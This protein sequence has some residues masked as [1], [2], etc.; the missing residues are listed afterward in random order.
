MTRAGRPGREARWRSEGGGLTF[1]GTA[2]Q[3]RLAITLPDRYGM[4]LELGV[5][6]NAMV[7]LSADLESGAAD[8]GRRQ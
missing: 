7:H 4:E 2:F 1:S 8:R 3:D 5:R 6:G